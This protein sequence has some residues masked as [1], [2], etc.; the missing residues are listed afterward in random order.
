M[1]CICN[2]HDLLKA[3][4]IAKKVV[5]RHQSILRKVELAATDD[6]WLFVRATDLT[7]MVE[8]YVEADVKVSG[9][10]LLPAA[11]LVD[12]VR[13]LP[14]EPV[15]IIGAWPEKITVGGVDFDGWDRDEFPEFP[16]TAPKYSQVDSEELQVALKRTSFA[17]SRDGA[18]QQLCGVALIPGHLVG[19][20]GKRLAEYR[21]PEL[22]Q[23]GILPLLAVTAVQDLLAYQTDACEISI[24]VVDGLATVRTAVGTVQ[25]RC[26]PGQL[27]D[28]LS[29][30]PDEFDATIAVNARVLR[31]QVKAAAAPLDKDNQ[32]VHLTVRG[33]ELWV[34]S[35]ATKLLVGAAVDGMELSPAF[36]V[37]FL[38]Q[39]LAA[40]GKHH[41]EI[42]LLKRRGPA[43]MST[44]AWRYAFMPVMEA[45]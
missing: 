43:V 19:C 22:K 40:A 9:R 13:N 41:V 4:R 38:L 42:R 2:H 36:A 26:L 11:E 1:Q 3:L 39:A 34:E 30:I 28:Y 5:S 7:T 6:G 16:P 25:T 32:V 8:I 31:Q 37:P 17:A 21:I 29:L 12:L 27:P 24:G 45:K 23:E 44:D 20:D 33:G 10:E 18:R 35:T 15:E 14:N